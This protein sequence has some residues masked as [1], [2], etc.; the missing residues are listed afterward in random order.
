VLRRRCSG[1]V[2]P[3]AAR[4]DAYANRPLDPPPDGSPVCAVGVAEGLFEEPFLPTDEADLQEREE[5]DHDEQGANLNTRRDDATTGTAGS[6]ASPREILP[7]LPGAHTARDRGTT[8]SCPT[9]RCP[10]RP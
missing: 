3:V 8:R 2:G 10:G 4:L 1:G 9:P 6:A 7:T 5:R